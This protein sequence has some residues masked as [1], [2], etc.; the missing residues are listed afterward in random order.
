MPVDQNIKDS[1]ANLRLDIN[2][3]KQCIKDVSSMV[4]LIFAVR[5]KKFE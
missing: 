3:D 2:S 4:A 1:I 5:E